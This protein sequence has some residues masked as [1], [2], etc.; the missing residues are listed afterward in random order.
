MC[1]I[2]LSL[3]LEK[4]E[5]AKNAKNKKSSEREEEEERLQEAEAE[6]TRVTAPVLHDISLSVK[7][8]RHIYLLF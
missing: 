8:V 3:S 6:E 4:D 2:C 7:K 5:K 1:V